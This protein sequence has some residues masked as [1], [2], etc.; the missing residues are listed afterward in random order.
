MSASTGH[1]PRVEGCA[2]VHTYSTYS[3]VQYNT[4]AG[5]LG[6]PPPA[7][8]HVP[9]LPQSVPNASGSFQHVFSVVRPRCARRLDS[10]GTHTRHTRQ[11][12]SLELA[13]RCSFRPA[14]QVITIVLT[15]TVWLGNPHA[16][17]SQRN[18]NSA[19]I[20]SHLT[21]VVGSSVVPF[22]DT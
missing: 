3:T 21:H 15:A 18:P 12:A 8:G 1:L 22:S 16:W 14:W 9:L 5:A 10:A 20:A 7:A 17:P 11:H 13:S 4:H 19:Q 6:P 2:Q